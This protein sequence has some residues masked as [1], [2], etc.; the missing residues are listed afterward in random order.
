M[1]FCLFPANLYYFIVSAGFT[2]VSIA[3]ADQCVVPVIRRMDFIVDKH[4]F[5]LISHSQVN[6]NFDLEISNH[7]LDL[8]VYIIIA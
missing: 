4:S 6:H 7:S 1:S 3:F 8:N 2:G 5:D